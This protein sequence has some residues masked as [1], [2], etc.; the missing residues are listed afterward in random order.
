[1]YIYG[2]DM[3]GKTLLS[4]NESAYTNQHEEIDCCPLEGRYYF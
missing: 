4:Q 1:M 2:W 3:C